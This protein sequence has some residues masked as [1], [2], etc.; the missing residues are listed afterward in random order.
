MKTRTETGPA[1]NMTA[2]AMHLP[3]KN[4]I[5]N[6]RPSFEGRFFVPYFIYIEL[7]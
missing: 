6:E 5:G 4:N 7:K 1:P 3:T 2:D